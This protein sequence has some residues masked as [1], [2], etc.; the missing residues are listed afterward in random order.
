MGLCLI[1]VS[2]KINKV[3]CPNQTWKHNNKA[4]T[5]KVQA[6]VDVAI[7]MT[8]MQLLNTHPELK[9]V[10][11]VI[12]DRDFYD[13]FK[14]VKDI[15]VNA[16]VFGFRANLSRHI[17]EVFPMDRVVYINDYWSSYISTSVQDEFPP[18]D[19]TN[20]NLT[21]IRQINLK[22]TQSEIGKLKPVTD[23]KPPTSGKKKKS[24]NKNRKIPATKKEE[25]KKRSNYWKEQSHSS[26]DDSILDK[27]RKP[28]PYLL[29]SDSFIPIGQ[30]KP[31]PHKT[32][33]KESELDIFIGLGVD[34]SKVADS[35]Q[36]NGNNLESTLDTII[37]S[38][39]T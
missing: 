18:L 28:F 9:N 26:T 30:P 22:K 19:P 33:L 15:E 8:T 16:W 4:F 21:E 29:Y 36:Q 35:Y 6:E 27:M 32:S 24:K 13:M 23:K 5:T 11:F 25:E 2:S 1:S 38:F 3:K 39:N 20:V 37:D 34:E 10:V 31:K 14:Y 12:G 17:F 7:T